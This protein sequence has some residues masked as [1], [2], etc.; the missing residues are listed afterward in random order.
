MPTYQ[1]LVIVEC[2]AL[3]GSFELVVCDTWTSKVW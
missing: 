2:A 3:A 1:V